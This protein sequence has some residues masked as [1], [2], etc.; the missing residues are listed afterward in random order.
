MQICLV[1][2]SSHCLFLACLICLISI[3]QTKQHTGTILTLWIHVAFIAYP[4]CFH[5]Q[6]Y[7]AYPPHPVAVHIFIFQVKFKTSLID[8]LEIGLT[9][10]FPGRQ[11]FSTA[12]TMWTRFTSQS[13]KS[14]ELASLSILTFNTRSGMIFVFK[15]LIGASKE[16]W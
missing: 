8:T 4:M 10:P 6:V 5:T 11:T 16:Q 12:L 14:G 13:V 9:T 2:N 3:F 1:L 7:L 15:T